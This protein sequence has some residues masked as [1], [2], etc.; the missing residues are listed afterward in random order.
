MNYSQEQSQTHKYSRWFGT[1]SA[2][3]TITGKI[4]KLLGFFLFGCYLCV[5]WLW[6]CH[7]IVFFFHLNSSL[8]TAETRNSKAFSFTLS[9]NT[10]QGKLEFKPLLK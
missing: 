8:D 7:L 6:V 9:L 10:I 2:I 5:F 3:Q 1:L 4:L